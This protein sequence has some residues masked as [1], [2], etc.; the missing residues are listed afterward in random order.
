[1][2]GVID[3]KGRLTIKNN[4]ARA[5]RQI[6]LSVESTEIPV[7]RRL[8]RMTGG[9]P[10][11][12]P[13]APLKDWMRRGCNDHCPEP[14]VHIHD[15]REM[16]PN[17][18]WTLTGASA[19]VVMITLL[20][21]L[22]VDKGFEEVI[23]EIVESVPLAGQGATAVLRSLKRLSDLGWDLPERFEQAIQGW[24]PNLVEVDA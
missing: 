19:A 13:Q 15:H 7:V 24:Q 11:A 2:A 9:R 3:L 8:A 18:R 1:M 22:T 5:T 6:V 14:H 12:R 21:F 17:L 16:P 20:P 4:K 10:E 23:E